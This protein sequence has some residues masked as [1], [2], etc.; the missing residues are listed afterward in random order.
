MLLED[1]HLRALVD[2]ALIDGVGHGEVDDADEEDAIVNLEAMI[3]DN[4]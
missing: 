3:D 2:D 4:V 1:G